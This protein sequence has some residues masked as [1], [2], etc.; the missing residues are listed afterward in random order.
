MAPPPVVGTLAALRA[1]YAHT[2]LARRALA[3]L[4]RLE[5][6]IRMAEAH[7]L[8]DPALPSVVTTT[9]GDH[10][11]GASRLV[12]AWS[13]RDL[14]RDATTGV[15]VTSRSR[16]VT[17]YS[18]AAV[19]ADAIDDDTDP[20]A[21]AAAGQAACDRL[22]LELAALETS[23]AGAI[24]AATERRLAILTAAGWTEETP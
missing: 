24:A 5:T 11:R 17:S 19:H 8:P 20:T 10:W 9:Y 4:E 1:A 22:E 15:R 13:A 14:A 7:N 2:A 16:D 3:L 12:L 23:V 21:L 18:H 6:T